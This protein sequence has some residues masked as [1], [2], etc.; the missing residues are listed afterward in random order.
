MCW[1]VVFLTTSVKGVK[2]VINIAQW[3]IFL[4]KPAIARWK[5]FRK[6][7]CYCDLIS[8]NEINNNNTRIINMIQYIETASNI[9]IGINDTSTK[10]VHE[11]RRVSK[12]VRLER[13]HKCILPLELFNTTRRTML[14]SGVYWTTRER[15]LTRNSLIVYH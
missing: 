9:N 14:V 12:Y 3:K 11:P 1:S 5:L 10:I 2:C 8:K 7:L 6:C 13:L 15:K 4:E